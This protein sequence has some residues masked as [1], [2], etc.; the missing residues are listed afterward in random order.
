[1]H[2]GEPMLRLQLGHVIVDRCLPHGMWLDRSEHRAVL[3][4]I[5]SQRRTGVEIN[6]RLV[7]QERVERPAAAP[8]GGP[9]SARDLERT[10][11][12]V[13]VVEKA[14]AD[15]DR[16]RRILDRGLEVLEDRERY[17]DEYHYFDLP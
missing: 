12:L 15:E 8:S 10:K 9:L 2:C 1:M 16:Q 14:H 6:V 13:K 11:K 7:G 17:D 5:H 3:A 4:M